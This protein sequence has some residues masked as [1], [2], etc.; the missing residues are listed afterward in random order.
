MRFKKN[1]IKENIRDIIKY[2]IY[3]I[4]EEIDKSWKI[5]QA[6][7]IIDQRWPQTDDQGGD[8]PVFIFSAGW[9]SGSTLMQRLAVS[10]KELAIWGEPF[11]DSAIIP[12]LAYSLTPI[13]KSWPDAHYFSEDND[14][15]AMSNQWIAN[16]SPPFAYLKAS[17]KKF[18]E[19]W[20]KTPAIERYGVKRW[21]IKEVRLTIDHARYLKWLFPNA[22]FIFM[23]RNLFDAYRSWKGN[24]WKSSWPGYHSRSPIVFAKHW[25]MLLEGYLKGCSEV[26]GIMVCFENLVNRKIDLQ[27]IARHIQVSQ[28]DENVLDR[29]LDAYEQRKKKDRR[30]L[31]RT[32]VTLLKMVGGNLMKELGYKTP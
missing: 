17:H 13:T 27:E 21:G 9:R 2:R 8:A 11:D 19:N 1:S 24:Q 32:D 23:Y 10:S 31:T 25:K 3:N 16:L 14:L 29:K 12:R 5:R 7:K 6:I 15:T 30:K 18:Y 20:L 28:I 26:D 22:R 4:P